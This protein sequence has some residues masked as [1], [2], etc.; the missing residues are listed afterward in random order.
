MH[1]YFRSFRI[2]FREEVDALKFMGLLKQGRK[3]D[4]V[5]RLAPYKYNLLLSTYALNDS[6]TTARRVSRYVAWLHEHCATNGQ[7]CVRVLL[8]RSAHTVPHL[9]QALKVFFHFMS[10]YTF[11][12]PMPGGLMV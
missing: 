6:A 9:L 5:D 4:H 12:W 8:K 7:V 11:C 10:Q 2:A 3:T 1:A